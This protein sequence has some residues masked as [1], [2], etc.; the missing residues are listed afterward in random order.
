MG[1]NR[2]EKIWI[3]QFGYRTGKITIKLYGYSCD[4]L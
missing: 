4:I 1:G 2:T 3:K